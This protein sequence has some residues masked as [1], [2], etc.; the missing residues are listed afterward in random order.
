MEDLFDLASMRHDH[1]V[2]A[3]ALL[4]SRLTEVRR[5]PFKD[6]LRLL[7]SADTIEVV[8]ETGKEYQIEIN[9]FWDDDEMTRLMVCGSVDDGGLR[10]WAN[11]SPL[12]QGF[13]AYPDGRTE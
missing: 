9:A 12:V 13:I 5:R 8:G 2:E 7:D 4:T 6:L 10:A 11:W 1:I 3:A